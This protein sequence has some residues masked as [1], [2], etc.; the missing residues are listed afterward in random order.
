LRRF[1]KGWGANLKGQFRRDREVYNGIMVRL[2]C[3]NEMVGLSDL[4]WRER[5]KAEKEL[6]RLFSAEEAY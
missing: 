1:L 6:M 4:E 3:R 2:D 5:Y